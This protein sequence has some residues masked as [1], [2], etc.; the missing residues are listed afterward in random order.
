MKNAYLHCGLIGIL[1]VCV[2]SLFVSCAEGPTEGE[3]GAG[4]TA[5][6]ALEADPTSIP[7]DGSSSSAIKATLKDSAGDPV[8]KGTLVSFSTTLGSF[9]NGRTFYTGGTVDDEGVLTVSLIAGTASGTALVKATSGGVTQTVNVESTAQATSTVGSIS[10]G[11][12]STTVVA[13][14]IST[15]TITATV[16]DSAQNPVAD[17]TTVAFVNNTNYGTLS[18]TSAQTSG[19][20][21]SVILTSPTKAGYAAIIRA[22][23]SNLTDTITVNFIAGPPLR[24]YADVNPQTIPAVFQTCP[25]DSSRIAATVVDMNDNPVADG[26]EV[27]FS[28]DRGW[29]WDNYPECPD[30]GEPIPVVETKTVTTS[31]GS[32]R[33]AV[34]ADNR[35]ETATVDICVGGLC[36]EDAAGNRGVQVSYGATTGESS[37]LPNNIVLSLSV[38]SIQVK[39]TGGTETA[40]INAKVK[41]ETGNPIN[42]FYTVSDGS[43]TAGSATLTS[44]TAKFQTRGF[45]AGDTLTINSGNDNGVYTISSVDSDTQV[46]LNRTMTTTASGLN[47][48]A[49]V[50]G[51]ITFTILLGPDGGENIDGK[52]A[53][54]S[55][56]TKSTV[57]GEANAV[58]SSGTYPGSVTVRV[59][60]TQGGKTATATSPVIGIESGPPFNITLYQDAGLEDNGD[61]TISQIISALVQDQYGNPVA[62]NTAIYFGVVDNAPNGYKINGANGATSATATFNSAGT[63]FP[64]AGVKQFDTLIIQ[65]GEDEGGYIIDT[66]ANGSVTLVSTLSGNEINLDFVAGNAERGQICGVVP[67]G[68]REPDGTCTPSSGT[69]VK[70]VAHTRLTWGAPG[71]W[72]P[73]NLYAATQG[74]GL[75][76]ALTDSYPGVTRVG[77]PIAIDVTIIPSKVGQPYT[78]IEVH[79]HLHDGAVD[80]HDISGVQL[81]FITSNTALTGFGVLGTATYTDPVLTVT[82]ADGKTSVSNL[83]TGG[84][85]VGSDTTVT[86]TV[87]GGGYSG[88]ATLT[89]LAP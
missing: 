22:S 71:I 67:T 42:D 47:F 61:G 74:R 64:T 66:P 3:L 40:T 88:T 86:I 76:R 78:G 77:F 34:L 85:V 15:T 39:G 37:G 41:D 19:G 30:P 18:A 69:A 60:C 7:A 35:V 84:A 48:T 20:A 14:G 51:N 25:D 62:N 81:T 6:I 89:I 87:S 46:T 68:N 4:Q 38:T 29:I 8:S 72:Q 45:S 58:L 56:S 12:G 11:A 31:N 28:I 53:V 21:A 55:T 54:P 70:G 13:D 57:N 73:Y 33:I 49:T 80:P 5:S 9:A 1:I 27:V 44:A 26:T 10:L 59:T 24:I 83:L 32:A 50:I 52:T 75:G 82:N 43:T 63:D 79:A 65:E 36:Y 17:G 16:L 23:T 2:S